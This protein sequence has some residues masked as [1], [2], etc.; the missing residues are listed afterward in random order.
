MTDTADRDEPEYERDLL[1]QLTRR[2]GRK[3]AVKKDELDLDGHFD[4]RLPDFPEHLVPVLS[5]PGADR[6]DRDARDRILSA[7]WIA[8]NAKTAAIEDE[9]ILPACRL[10]LQERI[11]VRRDDIAVA[12]LHQTIIDEHYH[13][14]MCH[15]AVGVTRRRRDLGDVRFAPDIWSVVRGRSAARAGLSG[16]DRDIV[17]I[18]FSLAAET[19]ISGFLSTLSTARTIQPMN[20][21]TTDLHRRDESGHAVVF[22]ELCGSLYRSLDPAQQEMFRDALVSGLAAFR[23]ADLDSWVAV[24]AQ[25]GFEIGADQLRDWAAT[26]PAP[27]RDTGPL[28]LLLGDLGISPDLVETVP[29]HRAG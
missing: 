14:L 12:A 10:M 20:R 1:L 9:I 27:A 11:P 22:R 7:A 3:V 18:A 19:T 17:D 16:F 25:G 13:I 2:W 21:I 6:L 4:E 23:A 24:A 28:Q 5:L 29:V 15:N 26:R 8:Y